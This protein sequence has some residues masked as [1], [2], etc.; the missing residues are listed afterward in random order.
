MNEIMTNNAAAS[1]LP[2]YPPFYQNSSLAEMPYYPNYQNISLSE[3]KI[4]FI[5]YIHVK[6]VTLKGYDVSLGC[7]FSWLSDEKITRPQRND[8][9]AYIKWLSL[10]H[11]S[12]RKPPKGQPPEIITFS[13]GTQAT[14]LRAVKMFF[15]WTEAERLY[16]NVAK[17]L[18]GAKVNNS[19]HKKNAFEKEDCLTVLNSI[20]RTTEAGKRDYAMISLG[21]Y[22]G[23]RI[24][25]I[26]RANIGNLEVLGG[27]NVLYVQHKGH[28]EADDF[29][30]LPADVYEAIQDYLN[31]RA[32]GGKLAASSPLFCG[33]G[34]RNRGRLEEPT[35]SKIIKDR[36]KAAGYDSRRLTAHSLRH[37]A[38][39][40]F[41]KS[42]AS[43]REAQLFAGHA[44]PETTCIYIHDDQKATQNF[45]QRVFDYINGS[46]QTP[47]KR[48][49]A[50]ANE[51]TKLSYKAQE[52]LAKE[53]SELVNKYRD[54]ERSEA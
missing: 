3:L 31:T 37:T 48:I 4:R 27:E 42:G 35:I 47:A 23:M 10:P 45:E 11:E 49:E 36:L 19:V 38:I 14:Y 24:I 1:S 34:N 50:A 15:E 13:A 16:P 17:K 12:R 43:L 40:N 7:F 20:D 26:Q 39:T 2:Y 30:K 5:D 52:L 28:D 25:E 21:F 46:D 44:S 53:F 9:K 41:I 32:N 6:D 18:G 22:C 51:A 29:H 33:T 8:I 54:L